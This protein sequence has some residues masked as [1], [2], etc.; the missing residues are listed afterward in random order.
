MQDETGSRNNNNNKN[1]NFD[2]NVSSKKRN[3]D[4]HLDTTWEFSSSHDISHGLFR[5]NARSEKKDESRFLLC[6]N[7]HYYDYYVYIFIN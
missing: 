2:P 4:F 6:F 7:I 5:V 1:N 3:L